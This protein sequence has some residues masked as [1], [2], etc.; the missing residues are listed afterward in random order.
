MA[1]QEKIGLRIRSYREKL[2]M[3]VYDLTQKSGVDEK[4]INAVEKGEVIPALGV[5]TRLARALGVRVGTFTDDQYLPDPI[6]THVAENAAVKIHDSVV[7]LPGVTYHS[8]ALGKTDRNMD[9]YRVDLEADASE[10]LQASEGEELLICIAGTVELTYGQ[11]THTLSV[12]DTA[13]YNNVVKHTFK[14]VGG[15]AS[16]YRIF[17]MPC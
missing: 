6:I 17:Y 12:G 3:S 16:L 2:G 7:D 8:L 11:Q 14:A 13:Y 5:L 1:I 4:F 9:P 15:P 10:T